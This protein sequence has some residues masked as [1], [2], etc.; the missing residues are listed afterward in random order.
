MKGSTFAIILFLS[1]FL[2]GDCAYYVWKKQFTTDKN[3]DDALLLSL[4]GVIENPNQELFFFQPGVSRNLKYEQYLEAS[5]ISFPSSKPKLIFIHGWNP[6]ERDTDPFTSRT[7]KVDNIN[8]TFQNGIIHYQE[9]LSL[10]KTKY[11]LFLF[12]YRTSN[13]L[14][15]NADGF[16]KILKK[17]FQTSDKVIIVA[18]SM[19]GLVTRAAMKSEGYLPNLIDG[20]VTLG[21]PMYGSPFAS[22]AYLKSQSF[23]SELSAFLLETQGGADLS[24][25][26]QGLGQTQIENETNLVLDYIN[27]DFP[28]NQTFVSFAG[29]LS[30]PSCAGAETFYYTTGCTVLTNSNPSFVRNDGI[31]PEN[32]AFLGKSVF[33]TISKNGY[34]HSMMAFQTKD[35]DDTKS[36]EL[37]EEAI[38]QA[39]L[40]LAR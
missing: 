15:F 3:T 33:K 37:F 34:D 40:L 24:H 2:F 28:Y 11:D 16:L 18:H 39:D 10:A 20:V 23:V 17:T 8:G 9:D 4:V 35:I 21:S 31:V 38:L 13:G 6:L 5:L 7:R 27:Q 1:S 30:A 12:T 19:G 29:L 26:N 14:I 22:K 36:K 32:S 25:T